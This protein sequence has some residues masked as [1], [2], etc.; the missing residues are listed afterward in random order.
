[1]IGLFVSLD[2]KRHCQLCSGNVAQKATHYRK[3]KMSSVI[4]DIIVLSAT[5]HATHMTK[6]LKIV[7]VIWGFYALFGTAHTCQLG[8]FI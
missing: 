7:G 6:M 8:L 1:M 5:N 3:V 2:I 4:Y